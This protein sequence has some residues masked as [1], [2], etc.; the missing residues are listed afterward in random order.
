MTSTTA[1]LSQFAPT[2]EHKNKAQKLILVSSQEG[3]SNDSDA[4]QGIIE[5]VN[6][7]IERAEAKFKMV[8][9]RWLKKM[10]EE[11]P[12]LRELELEFEER[13]WSKLEDYLKIWLQRSAENLGVAKWYGVFIH[14]VFI[15]EI[16]MLIE[17]YFESQIDR[18]KERT[19][20]KK[21]TDVALLVE[22]KKE[23]SKDHD[24]IKQISQ[25]EKTKS[26]DQKK[27]KKNPTNEIDR[28]IQKLLSALKKKLEVIKIKFQDLS[29][30][31]L[32]KTYDIWK[33]KSQN[34]RK[35][36]TDF[37]NIKN[38]LGL[39]CE[40]E[41]SVLSA[42][43]AKLK[44]LKNQILKV[45]FNQVP[46]RVEF[47]LDKEQQKKDK[48]GNNPL[49]YCCLFD[50]FDLAKKLLNLHV[51]KNSKNTYLPLIIRHC[52]NAKKFFTLLEPSRE[53]L[54]A[55]DPE[56]RT[57]FEAAAYYG[58]HAALDWM[59][60][61]V[62]KLHPDFDYLSLKNAFNLAC[63]KSHEN[64]VGLLLP[65]LL[66]EGMDLR[67]LSEKSSII[68]KE[69]KD[70]IAVTFF[71]CGISP[72]F[73]LQKEFNLLTSTEAENVARCYAAVERHIAQ[74]RSKLFKF[75]L[76]GVNQSNPSVSADSLS[77]GT[78]LTR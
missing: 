46:L 23:Q 16:E 60:A 70:K 59:I 14:R 3:K 31:D 27:L 13:A 20:P 11:C 26:K 12:P 61:R 77:K 30:C 7:S 51:Y 45:D 25:P 39:E 52:S 66:R 29:F 75:C 9:K 68:Y 54:C 73:G 50:D 2:L 36:K 57:S 37:D 67:E 8:E 42:E 38:P 15:K 4:K 33:E 32:S 53:D 71:I 22:E 40:E 62:E 63:E 64:I 21:E 48:K 34:N 28:T 35:E 47:F 1:V 5:R 74:F 72:A 6:L 41:L 43:I 58:N 76:F 18:F 56:G 44:V 24:K 49:H 55:K 10:E 78:V 17:E 69:G 19:K 65:V